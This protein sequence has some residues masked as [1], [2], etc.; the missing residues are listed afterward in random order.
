[1]AAA[2]R[3]ERRYRLAT[4]SGIEFTLVDRGS[5]G[6]F[7]DWTP[8]GHERI[9]RH[10]GGGDRGQA[11]ARAVG[12][13]EE[14]QRRLALPVLPTLAR[15]G[16]ELVVAK[17]RAGNAH[18]YVRAIESHLRVHILP[19]F[20]PDTPITDIAHRPKLLEFKK[21]LSEVDIELATANRV[22]TTL[23]QLLKHAEDPSGWIS[24]PLLPKSFPLASWDVAQRW[25]LLAPVEVAQVIAAMPHELRPLL[26]F[27]ANTGLRIGSALATQHTWIDWERRAVHYP[28]GAMKGRR[29]HTIE[30]N[31]EALRALREASAASGDPEQPFPLS[32]WTVWRRWVE[33]C[34]E[35][36][37]PWPKLRIHDLRHSFVSNQLTAGTPIHVVRDLAAHASVVTTQ[38]YAHPTDEAR[39]AAVDRVKITA[40]A[41]ALPRRDTSR[42]TKRG[43]AG[44]RRE[45][46]REANSAGSLDSDTMGH[47]GLEPGAN[48]LR[49]HC[50]TN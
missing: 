42:D 4:P 44:A 45:T 1:M 41:Q 29:P 25:T 49:V 19:S 9:R 40:S 39:R 24:C 47:P 26:T 13:V 21:Y 43:S 17:T 38:L 36:D 7:V 3:G 8:P 33:R 50:S 14:L 5:R 15:A 18:N 46:P 28:P 32:Y 10:V 20:G 6:W 12:E 11:Q 48:G 34:S 23:R 2:K 30:L 22:L 35:D 31:S 16:A 27:V 37:F